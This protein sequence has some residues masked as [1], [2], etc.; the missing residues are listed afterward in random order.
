MDKVVEYLFD[1]VKSWPSYL[2]LIIIIFIFCVYQIENLIKFKAFVCSLFS[3]I[4]RRARKGQITNSLRGSILTAAKKKEFTSLGILPDDMKIMWAEDDTV[5]SFFADNKVVIRIRQDDNPNVNYVKI[6]SQFVTTGLFNNGRHHFDE[7]VLRAADIV[8]AQDIVVA[9]RPTAHKEFFEHVYTPA[10]NA[11]PEIKSDYDMLCNLS[12]AGLFYLVYLNELNKAQASMIG[13]VPDNCLRAES[14]EILY[15][16][17]NIALK[18]SDNPEDLN[19]SN[20]YFKF[21]IVFAINDH[22]MRHSGYKAHLRVIKK[23][24]SEEYKAIYVIASGRKRDL[25]KEIAYA[26]KNEC[27]EIVSSK[28]HKFTGVHISTSKRTEGICVELTTY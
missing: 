17:N 10:I 3:G 9:S 5:S 21:G 2:I 26:A 25:A 22:T 23:L 20:N 13:Q 1:I 7:T 27:P 8:V 12:K 14:R 18:R 15:F 19:I 24:V 28:T 16:L 11:Y 6:L 4:S